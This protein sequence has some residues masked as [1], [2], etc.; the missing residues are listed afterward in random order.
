MRTALIGLTMIALSGCAATVSE[1]GQ[2]VPQSSAIQPLA[3][4]LNRAESFVGK[5]G[6]AVAEDARAASG[7]KSVRVIRPGQA[8]TQDYRADRLN[9]ETDD[10]GNVVRVS[11][12]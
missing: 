8:V 12:G 7:A 9:L 5:P 1:P 6:D 10:A 4:N 3:C 2:A 11:C